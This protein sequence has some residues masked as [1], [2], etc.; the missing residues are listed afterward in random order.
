MDAVL[1]VQGKIFETYFTYGENYWT[2][3]QQRNAPFLEV[4]SILLRT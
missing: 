1:G 4:V 2:A 3:A